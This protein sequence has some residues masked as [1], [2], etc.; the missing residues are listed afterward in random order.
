M[1]RKR[2]CENPENLREL[3]GVGNDDIRL[4]CIECG[5]TVAH[6]DERGELFADY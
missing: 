6:A 5:T 1:H 3:G 2:C 4:V